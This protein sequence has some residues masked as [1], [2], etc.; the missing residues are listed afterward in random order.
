MVHEEHQENLLEAVQNLL[1]SQSEAAIGLLMTRHPAD[2]ADLIE[3]LS[4]ADQELL[5]EL[6][7]EEQLADVLEFLGEDARRRLLREWT[8]AELAPV[9]DQVD[10]DVAADIVQELEPEQAREVVILLE[11]RDSVSELLSYP[12]ESA[13]GRMSSDFVALRRN[14]TIEEAINFLRSEQPDTSHAF[15]LYTVDEEQRLQGVVSLRSVVTAAPETPVA[16]V[17]TEA[18]ISVG[19]H[20]D[21]EVAAE[22]MR[23][24]NLLAL[25]VIDADGRLVGVIS[26]D[27]VLDVQVEEATEDMFRMVGLAEEERLFRPIRESAPPRIAWLM[28]NLATAVLAASTVNF[29]EGT[30]EKVAAL[31]VFMPI[32]AGMGGN[33]GIQTI[34]LVVRSIAIGEVDV[35]DAAEILRHEAIIAAIK[36]VLIGL[37]VGLLAWVWKGNGWLGVIVGVSMLANIANATLVGVLVPLGLKRLKADPA[38]AS[39]VIVTTF[40]DVVGFLVFLGLATVFVSRLS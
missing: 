39:G 21:Q 8:P 14:W 18:V 26:A 2:Q 19:A 29:F 16:A 22:R 15:Y 31:A 35:R 38:L 10:E 27:D 36:G 3:Q 11:E 40:S 9:L 23:H 32:V 33:A 30:I 17:T 20:E 24:Y 13:G 4:A 28:L 7:S 5:V 12:E 34:T 37:V 6:L 1:K 25:P